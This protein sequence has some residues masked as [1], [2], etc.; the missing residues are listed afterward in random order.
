MGTTSN[1]T[2]LNTDN[3]PHLFA[4]IMHLYE[5]FLIAENY[6][7]K[8]IDIVK[9]IIRPELEYMVSLLIQYGFPAKDIAWNTVNAINGIP[10]YSCWHAPIP[11]DKR[12]EFE[13]AVVKAIKAWETNAYPVHEYL[14]AKIGVQ[15]IAPAL[16][17]TFK[18]HTFL[19]RWIEGL[20][21]SND[22]SF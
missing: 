3:I 16:A 12:D 5:E 22:P 8:R 21:P 19:P 18:S 2:Y 11:K 1:F 6:P 13:R 4:N 7:Q 20:H 17:A 15:R 14:P 10:Q 9:S